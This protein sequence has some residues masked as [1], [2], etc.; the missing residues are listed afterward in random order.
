[1]FIVII[2]KDKI[3]GKIMFAIK[4]PPAIKQIVA[5]SEGHC[6]LLKPIMACP[7]VHPPAYLVPKPTKNPPKTIIINPRNVNKDSKLNSSGGN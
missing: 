4:N 6:K 7:E 2:Y 3:Q 1:L 5:T